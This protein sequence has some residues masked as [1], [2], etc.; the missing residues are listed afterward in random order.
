MQKAA[1]TDRPCQDPSFGNLLFWLDS[2]DPFVRAIRNPDPAFGVYG[3]PMRMIEGRF[4]RVTPISSLS[5]DSGADDG[6]QSLVGFVQKANRLV[7]RIGNQNGIVTVDPKIFG[8]FE[9]RFLRG[10]VGD[11]TGFTCANNGGHRS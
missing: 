10:P 3:D 9:G 1:Q 11:G 4:D 8:A 7:G 5:N 2:K 6:G